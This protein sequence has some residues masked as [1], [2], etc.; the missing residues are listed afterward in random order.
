MLIFYLALALG[1]SFICSVLE[2]VILTV[3]LPYIYLKEKE[4]RA[5][6]GT[7]KKIKHNIDRPLAAILT[8]NTIAHTIGAAGVGSEATKLFGEVYFGIISAALTLLILI[9]SEI[10]PKT[11]GALYWRSLALPA[12]RIIRFFIIITYP[13]VIFSE[14]LTKVFSRGKV[15]GTVS[16]EE[17]AML[18]SLA[19]EEGVFDEMESKTI[20]NLIQLKDI[21]A[22][23]IMTPRTVVVAAKETLTTTEFFQ[24]PDFLQFSRIPIF[25]DN[26]DQTTG[27]V[28]KQDI[29]EHLLAGNKDETLLSRKR[30]IVTCYENVS[31]PKIFERLII[32]KE[33]IALI[34]NEYGGTEG[35]LTMEDIIETILGLEILDERDIQADMQQ[36]ARELWQKRR[37]DN[38][39]KKMF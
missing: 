6:A 19:S 10:I 29:L 26:L 24:T 36:L 21:K 1:I 30:P 18:A 31:I 34:V 4:G 16:R 9:F 32:K 3:S 37:N 38:N 27:Y 28:L 13:L 22:K 8:L 12:A 23:D 20:I 2:S 25:Q 35:I 14:F 33:H 39:L 5:G 15:S 7:L 17:L 11:I